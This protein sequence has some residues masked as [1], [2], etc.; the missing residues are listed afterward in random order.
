M[1]VVGDGPWSN[2]VTKWVSDNKLD[3]KVICYGQLPWIDLKKLY[4]DH[5]I[6]LYTSLRETF[7]MQLLEAM[8]FG[9]PIITLDC[10]GARDFIPDDAGFRIKVTT[11]DEIINNLA[12]AVERLWKD[13]ELRINMGKAAHQFAL[14]CTWEK[15]ALYYEQIYSSILKSYY[16][17]STK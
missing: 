11:L 1:S 5:D 12:G 10:F 4:I 9:L 6:F 13:P 8:A 2:K 7:G 3:G 17:N 15:T 16:A 14:G